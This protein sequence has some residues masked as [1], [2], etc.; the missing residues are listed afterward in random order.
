MFECSPYAESNEDSGYD[1][2]WWNVWEQN[3]HTG[4]QIIS[5]HTSRDEAA[6]ECERA[7]D[8]TGGGFSQY[9]VKIERR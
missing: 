7:N 4:H 2:L 5:S 9:Y 6:Q 3:P 8:A 1:V